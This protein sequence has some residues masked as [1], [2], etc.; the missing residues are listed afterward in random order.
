MLSKTDIKKLPKG[1]RALTS[2]P[3]FGLSRFATRFPTERAR[4]KISIT[5]KVATP[6]TIDSQLNDID[7]V[8]QQSD[9]HCV[10]TWS[11][12]S[13]QWQGYRFRDIY[14]QII[15]PEARPLEDA[16]ILILKG[17][18]GARTTL[19]VEDALN[20]DVLLAVAMDNQQLSIKQGGPM[21]IVAPAHYGYKSIKFLKSIEFHSDYSRYNPPSFRFMDHPRARVAYEERG[22]WV[23]GWLLRYLYRPLVGP[24]IRLFER[25]YKTHILQNPEIE[26]GE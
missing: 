26:Q 9:F 19:L 14:Q 22:R 5:G 24:T 21:R 23:P 25:E 13:I 6:I 8:E 10:T 16:V 3:C 2:M 7:L 17:Q 15:L 12:Q 4:I 20:D 1:Q 11:Y 18:D